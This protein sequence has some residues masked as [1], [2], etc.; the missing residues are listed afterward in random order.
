MER[1]LEDIVSCYWVEGNGE[2]VSSPN[3]GQLCCA[4]EKGGI[5]KFCM[6]SY[7]DVAY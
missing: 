1:G 4:I 3:E 6:K 5:S 2:E 7:I